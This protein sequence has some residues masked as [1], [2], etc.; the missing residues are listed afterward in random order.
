L[1]KSEITAP[2]QPDYM[3]TN[4]LLSEELKLHNQSV[5]RVDERLAGMDDEGPIG[6][7]D[8][9]NEAA[10]SVEALDDE[11]R[12]ALRSQMAEGKLE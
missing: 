12:C 10:S 6:Y 3:S 4:P 2:E 7:S 9:D 5:K 8:I 1:E 11:F